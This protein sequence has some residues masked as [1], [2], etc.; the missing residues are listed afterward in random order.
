MPAN[1]NKLASFLKKRTGKKIWL[2][3][4]CTIALVLIGFGLTKLALTLANTQGTGA[5][6]NP[7]VI[8]TNDVEDPIEK[9]PATTSYN[10]PAD[11]PK[12]IHL[13]TLSATGLIQRV[14]LNK[15]G[16]IAVPTNVHFAGWYTG[17]VKPGDVGLSI[18]DGHVSVKYSPFILKNIQKL[19]KNDE[20]TV[21]YG[22]GRLQTFRVVESKSLPE[23]KSAQYL[24]DK[25]ADIER[26]LNLITCDGAYDR[27]SGQYANRLVVVARAV[28]S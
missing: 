12:T 23:H 17:S 14:G 15:Q 20:F 22:D 2:T 1:K 16:A 3:L 18:I 10:V 26:Q 9:K 24:S 6:P 11:Q 27:Q 8:I 28:A 4:V 25:R 13:P 7:Q 19:Q 21:E 5:Q